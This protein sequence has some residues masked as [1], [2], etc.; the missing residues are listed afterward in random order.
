MKSIIYRCKGITDA[1]DRA[2]LYY[3]SVPA[4]RG[5][6]RDQGARAITITDR[7]GTPMAIFSY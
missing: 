2:N 3:I 1:T 5:L 6:K 4:A 7:K